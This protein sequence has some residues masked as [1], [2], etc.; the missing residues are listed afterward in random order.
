MQ[1]I[2]ATA[3]I[4]VSILLTSFK[5]GF[6]VPQLLFVKIFMGVNANSKTIPVMILIWLITLP[7][8]YVEVS[9][10]DL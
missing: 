5:V 8:T 1:S 4:F 10:H 2:V 7:N 3:H 6:K 9:F